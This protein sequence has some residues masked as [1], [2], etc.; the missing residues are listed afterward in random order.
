MKNDQFSLVILFLLELFFVSYMNSLILIGGKDML[1]NILPENIYNSINKIPYQSLC[2]LRLRA[3]DN[4]VVN[5][6]GENYYLCSDSLSK[7]E[8]NALRVNL[9]TMQSIIQRLSKFSLYSVNDQIIDGYISY[10]GGIRVGVCGEVVTV[11]NSIKTIKNISSINIRFPH[12]VKNCSLNIYPYII[13]Q[14]NEIKSTLIISPPGAGKTTFLRDIIYQLSIRHKLLNILVVDERQELA[15]IYNGQDITKL[16][17]VDVYSNCTKKFAF[18]NGIRS[19]KPD[20]IVTDE[21]NIERDLYDIENALTSGVKVFA[22]I[23]AGSVQELKQKNGFK[24]LVEKGLFE[25]F[26]VL[27]KNNGLGTIEGIFNENLRLIGV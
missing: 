7:S 8:K 10:D 13:D 18:N 16:S 17:N 12:F 2:E 3:N 4:I 19:M 26:V 15:S 6:S 5:V 14:N 27:S 22:S 11:E 23:H 24:D 9:G 1:K 25:R 21:I 20:V